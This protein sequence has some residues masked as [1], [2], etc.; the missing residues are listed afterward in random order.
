MKVYFLR[1]GESTYNVKGLINQDKNIPVHL[2]SKGKKQASEVGR[3]LF[4]VGFDAIYR[5][6]FLRAKETAEIASRNWKVPVF[7]DERLNEAKVGFEGES[8]EEFRLDSLHDF[9]KFK[10]KG[11][12][13]WLDVKKRIKSFMKDLKKEK[14]KTVLVVSHQ[15]PVEIAYEIVNKIS[16]KA[17]REKYIGNCEFYELEI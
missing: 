14:Y 10:V 4:G 1:H 16:D 7:V 6:E 12:E 2:T 3:K 8:A 15:W 5:S 9:Y 17:A 13:S 11:Q